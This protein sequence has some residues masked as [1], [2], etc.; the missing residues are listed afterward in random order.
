[1]EIEGPISQMT[2]QDTIR[3]IHNDGLAEK[4]TLIPEIILQVNEF[5]GRHLDIYA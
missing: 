3:Q 2:M 1:M 5:I 4:V